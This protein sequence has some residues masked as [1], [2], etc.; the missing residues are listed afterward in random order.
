[1][2]RFRQLSLLFYKTPLLYCREIMR[3]CLPFLA[4]LFSASAL[5]AQQAAPESPSP[6]DSQPGQS[7]S[8]GP[9][10]SGTLGPTGHCPVV[11]SPEHN[12]SPHDTVSSGRLI[13]KVNPNYPAALRRAN[14]EGTVVLCATIGRDGKLHNLLALSGP[15]ELIPYALEA[16]QQ[17]RYE[18]Y[19]VN[20]KPVDVNS[21]VRLDFRLGR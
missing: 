6:S 11:P 7:Q 21:E 13:R 15:Q 19:R 12:A 4:L 8:I 14:I 20:K 9:P 18:P 5:V 16:L 17:W 1:M 10:A 2:P 3:T